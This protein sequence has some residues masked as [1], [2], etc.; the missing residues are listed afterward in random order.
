LGFT[1]TEFQKL[2]SDCASNPVVFM[3]EVVIAPAP[4]AHHPPHTLLY[5]TLYLKFVVIEEKLRFSIPQTP[6]R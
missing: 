4:V 6:L 3:N 1:V 2:I 5:P